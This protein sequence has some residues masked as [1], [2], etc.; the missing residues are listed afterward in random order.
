[1]TM[2]K[3][4]P[5]TMRVWKYTSTDGG[6]EKTLQLHKSEPPPK[7]SPKEHLV[8]VLAVGLN[9]VD[10][11]PAESFAGRFMIKKPA[12]P[13]FDIAGRILAPAQGSKLQ[14]GDLIFGAAS[15]N[16]LAG[17]ALAEYIAAPAE[18][19]TA[20]PRGVSPLQAAGAP[21]AAVTAHD[22]LVPYIQKGSRVFINGGSG[23]VGTYGIQIAKAIGALV[24]VSCSAR[25]AE[26]CRSLGADEV[27]D[28]NASPLIDQLRAAKPFDHVVDN[29]FNDPKLYFQ[30]HTYTT[31]AAKFAEVASGPSLAF[32]KFALQASLLPSF[33]G[34]GRRKCVL[35]LSD[36]KQHTLDKIGSWFVDGQVKTVIDQTFTFEQVVDAYK[37]QK[38]GRAVGKVIVDV[39]GE[40]NAW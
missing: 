39:A 2:T 33:F 38:T 36:V 13:G 19:V 6:I 28:Y 8:Q 9:P 23:G 15:T 24:T 26:L 35:V 10:Y 30:A 27:F 7:P 21:V 37:R 31:P 17:G 12:T 29:V 32:I 4:T 22:S 5:T 34:G 14:R 18:R 20:L 25:N 16:P 1:M 40:G 11:K 3:E